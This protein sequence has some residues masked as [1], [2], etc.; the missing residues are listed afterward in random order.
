MGGGGGGRG[1]KQGNKV[2]YFRGTKEPKSK[3]D[4]NRGSKAIW[5]NKEHNKSRF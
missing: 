2:I 4:E 3:T 1:G 5:G